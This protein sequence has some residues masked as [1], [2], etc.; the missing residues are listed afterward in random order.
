[1][2]KNNK[3]IPKFEINSFTTYNLFHKKLQEFCELLHPDLK[4]KLQKNLIYNTICNSD[5]L[6]KNKWFNKNN[7][8]Y[9][10]NIN[11]LKIITHIKFITNL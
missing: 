2:S 10:N 4:K 7:N 9:I 11:F 6:H 3:P 5:R 1:M 8:P